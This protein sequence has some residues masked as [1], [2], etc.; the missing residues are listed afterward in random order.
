MC[1]GNGVAGIASLTV[2]E[3]FVGTSRRLSGNDYF[4]VFKSRNDVCS[5]GIEAIGTSIR[6]VPLRIAG[7]DGSRS[8]KC[9]S[10]R[11]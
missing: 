10:E 7:R 11:G 5:E 3:T 4:I 1:Y 8:V 9:V 2:R 6:C